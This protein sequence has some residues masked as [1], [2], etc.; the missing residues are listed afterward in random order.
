MGFL[1]KSVDFLKVE[2]LSKGEEYDI[3][4]IGGGATG[5][6]IALDSVSR[7]S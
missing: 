5:C 6:G 3:L 4:V 2:S 7:G 1:P